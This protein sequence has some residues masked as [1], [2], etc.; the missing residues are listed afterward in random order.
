MDSL[1]HSRGRTF[2]KTSLISKVNAL[3][4]FLELSFIACLAVEV[5]I[6]FMPAVE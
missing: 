4:I 6:A 5:G 1:A 3:S 2:E